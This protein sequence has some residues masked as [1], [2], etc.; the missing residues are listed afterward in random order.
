RQRGRGEKAELVFCAG[1]SGLIP[2]DFVLGGSEYFLVLDVQERQAQ[3]QLRGKVH[4]RSL[5][6]IEP[7]WLFDWQ[8]SLLEEKEELIW[9]RGKVQRLVRLNYGQLLIEES[10]GPA[11]ESGAAAQ[12]FWREGLGLDLRDSSFSWNL[13]NLLEK[14]RPRLDVESLETL[15]SRLAWLK[16]AYGDS[17]LP[18]WEGEGLRDSLQRLAAHWRIEE[19]LSSEALERAAW[20]AFGK[21]WEGKVQRLLPTS[22][23]LPSGRKARI[24]YP[25]GREPWIESRLQDFFGM[26]QAPLLAEGRV[27][28]VIHLLAPNGRAVQVTRD[29][30]GFWKNTYPSVRLELKRRYPKHAWPENPS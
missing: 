15:F 12:V 11:P 14:L 4:V 28:L 29:L 22:F 18:D 1:G 21:A 10:R 5:V 30:A 2:E 25:W 26:R 16:K 27:P 8:G 20:N 24:H 6:A 23:T 19:G 9:E 17:E 13:P 7:E 3:G